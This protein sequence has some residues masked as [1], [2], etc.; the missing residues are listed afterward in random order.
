MIKMRA[1]ALFAQDF[2]GAFQGLS[3]ESAKIALPDMVI[4]VGKADPEAVA[5]AKELG[6]RVEV[7]TRSAKK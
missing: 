5:V 3:G 2:V 6:F 1:A 4:R 7:T